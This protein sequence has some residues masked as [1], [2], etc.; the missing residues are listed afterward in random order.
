MH[1]VLDI[2]I[3]RKLAC[4]Q[5][6]CVLDDLRSAAK[7]QKLNFGP[8]PVT[9]TRC[10]LG[11]MLGYNILR[12]TLHG[13]I[14]NGERPEKRIV[15][16]RARTHRMASIRTAAALAGIAVGACIAGMR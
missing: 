11:G 13:E 4:V 15:R 9:H 5:P 1:R 12:L 10:T 2:D 8:D 3:A 16:R 6:D 7:E 14:S